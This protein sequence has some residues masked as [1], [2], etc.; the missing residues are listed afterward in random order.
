MVLKFVPVLS[1]PPNAVHLQALPSATPAAFVR[2]LHVEVSGRGRYTI[3]G[4]T[5]FLELSSCIAEC[6]WA[7]DLHST[8]LEF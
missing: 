8:L 6:T 4:P 5:L 1:M 3:Q 2:Y 7:R